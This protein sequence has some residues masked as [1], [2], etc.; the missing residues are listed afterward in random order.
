MVCQNVVPA[1]IDIRINWDSPISLVTDLVVTGTSL[2]VPGSTRSQT[3]C[4]R[5]VERCDLHG[6]S[7][8][9]QEHLLTTG[10]IYK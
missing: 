8:T 6:N 9:P 5:S 2:C 7:Q 3:F 4:V 10:Y 1:R